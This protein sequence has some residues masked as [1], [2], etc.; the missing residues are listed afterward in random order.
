M[1][2]T[3]ENLPET[4]QFFLAYLDVEKGYSN[5]TLNSYGLDLTQWETFL[6]TRN[7]SNVRPD[8]INRADIHAYLAELHH[9]GLAKSSIARKLSSLRAFFRFLLKKKYIHQ[10][11]CQGLKN[12]RQDKP[13]PRVLNVDQAL[14]LM[15]AELEPNPKN[16]RDIA[17]A[18]LLYGS[19]LRIS[20][21]LNLDLDDIDLKQQIVRVR[22]KGSKEKLAPVTQAGCT[23]IKNYLEQRTAF[24]PDLNEHALF[25]GIRGKRLQRREANRILVRLSKLAGL[26]Q[27]ISPHVLRHSFATH[28]LQSGADLRSVQE[29]LGHSRISTTQRYTHLNL[30]TVIKI[31][32]KAHPRAGKENK[33]MES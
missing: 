22:G 29:L 23:R 14:N 24:N 30:E 25:L 1:S 21:A 10:N 3:S 2:W 26:P 27:A 16:L 5:A 20:E 31:Y 4:I 8:E 12:P 7:K 13:Q 6:K 28:L 18:E 9:Q 32:D 33:K 15:Q 11:P 17:L 19:G